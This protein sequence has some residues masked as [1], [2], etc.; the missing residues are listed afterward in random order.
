MPTWF[1]TGCSTGLG[2]WLAR[3]VLARGRNAFVTARDPAS[4]SD[5]V[6]EHP[7]TA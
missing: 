4:I 5:K 7:K 3:A 6:A 2:R 1:I